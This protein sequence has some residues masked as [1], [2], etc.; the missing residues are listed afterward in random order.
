MD[1][2]RRMSLGWIAGGAVFAVA[3][4]IAV[5]AGTTQR[6]A[7]KAHAAAA[8]PAAAAP[9]AQASSST[10]IQRYQV[11][12]TASQPSKGP[13]DAIVT[14][15]EWCELRSAEC[16]AV[17]SVMDS[18]LAQYGDMVRLVYRHYLAS[19]QQPPIA[20][21]FT[22]IAHEQAG[23]FW[24]ARALLQ[25]GPLVPSP[26]ELEGYA[27]QLGLDWKATHAALD[28]HTHAG[29][30]LADRLF[31][32][33]FDVKGVPAFFVNGRKLEGDA[34]LPAFKSLI[35]DEI[36][37]ANELV[38]QGIP[39]NQVYAELTKNGAWKQ[40]HVRPN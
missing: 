2:R 4:V 23:K 39:K 34:T 36:E 26:E 20:E 17:D 16:K 13:Q 9:A 18:V 7:P 25:K 5:R 6:P 31:A 35:D 14:I 22:R 29:S 37:R 21:E 24:E 15:V 8:A 27:K 30:V 1:E 11:P 19:G 28:E 3:A 40:V 10:E 12:V 38:A 32:E 33:M